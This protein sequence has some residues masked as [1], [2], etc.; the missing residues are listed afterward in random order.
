MYLLPK[1]LFMIPDMS[2]DFGI[3][4]GCKRQMLWLLPY[5]QMYNLSNIPQELISPY[6]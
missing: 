1:Q 4:V 2:D 6:F 5:S 3:K